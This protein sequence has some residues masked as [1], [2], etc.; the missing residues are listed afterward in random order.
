VSFNNG[1]VVADS[2]KPGT[3]YW[4]RFSFTHTYYSAGPGITD[5]TINV[6]GSWDLIG[7]IGVPVISSAI[8]TLPPDIITSNIYGFNRVFSPSDSIVPGRGYWVKTS[9]PGKIILSSQ[10]NP[11]EISS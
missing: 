2:L 6:D 3:G 4:T 8:T 10:N 11:P 1:Y 7:S 9:Q 5:D